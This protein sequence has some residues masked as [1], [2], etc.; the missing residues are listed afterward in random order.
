MR[1]HEGAKQ[2]GCVTFGEPL[3]TRALSTALKLDWWLGAMFVSRGMVVTFQ[4]ENLKMIRR[5]L[6][7]AVA[8]CAVTQTAQAAA[9]SG[10]ENLTSSIVHI[11]GTQY[12]F[13]FPP[14]AGPVTINKAEVVGSTG[15]LAVYPLGAVATLNGPLDISSVAG[16]TL[17]ETVGAVTAVFTTTGAFS[18]T[19]GPQG[20]FDLKGTL[21]MT[22]L[23]TSPAELD[24]ALATTKQGV[25]SATYSLATLAVPEPSTIGLMGLGTVGVVLAGVRRKRA[26]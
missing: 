8:V 15:D 19:P 5:M 24:I 2:R 10:T 11:S 18:I 12:T 13:F 21:S 7:L 22:G 26:A 1:V 17:T 14:P 16:F 23:G 25:T 3:Q 20:N 9:V 4:Q 6:M